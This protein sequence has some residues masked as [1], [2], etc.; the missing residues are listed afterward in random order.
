[1]L[2]WSKFSDMHF[3]WLVCQQKRQLS[4]LCMFKAHEF[5]HN[6]LLYCVLVCLALLN[7]AIIIICDKLLLCQ[8]YNGKIAPRLN[9]QADLEILL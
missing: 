1:M 3:K 7:D 4:I 8:V 9:L 2:T 5:G 6:H